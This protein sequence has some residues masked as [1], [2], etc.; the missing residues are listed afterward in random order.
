MSARLKKFLPLL[1]SFAKLN[2]KA[3]KKVLQSPEFIKCICEI[4]CNVL[5][6][7]V[8]LKKTHTQK[9]RP[10]KNILRKFGVKTKKLNLKAK[11]QYLLQKGGSFIPILLSLIAPIVSSLINR[12]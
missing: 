8:P 10:L 11:R 1:K 3:K 9:L 5:K 2:A 4:C 12:Q 7:N 6:G